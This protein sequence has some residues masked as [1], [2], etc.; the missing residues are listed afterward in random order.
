MDNSLLMTLFT[1]AVT[2]L[3]V[4]LWFGF[5]GL[6]KGQGDLH[7]KLT[8]IDKNVALTKQAFETHEREDNRRFSFLETLT[9]KLAARVIEHTPDA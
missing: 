8:D 7:L 4:V 3:G 6:A 2:G 5:R 9:A 1:L